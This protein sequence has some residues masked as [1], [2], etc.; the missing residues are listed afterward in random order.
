MPDVTSLLE[1]A[2]AEPVH[3]PDVESPYRRACR[4]RAWTV[5]AVAVVV[6]LG[7]ATG[8]ALRPDGTRR[9]RIA[10]ATP[11]PST[12]PSVS[13]FHDTENKFSIDIPEGF[14]RSNGVLEPWLSSP[15]EIISLATVPLT[16]YPAPPGVNEAAC[17]SEI[18]K[19]AINAIGDD[20]AFVGM[21]EWIVG[22]GLYQAS[23]RTAHAAD[24]DWQ[25]GCA[26]PG[27]MTVSIAT[28][29]DHGRD[30]TVAVVLGRAAAALRPTIDALLDSFQP[31]VR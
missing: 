28:F 11:A 9:V 1:R 27:G 6:A 15:H 20:G 29:D 14:Q 25:N 30:F 12:L 26:L 21:Y 13:T 17:P 8:V 5:A 3:G 10:P 7:I 22:R 23:P 16:P 4:R 19:V 18:P 31:A 24:L 2:A